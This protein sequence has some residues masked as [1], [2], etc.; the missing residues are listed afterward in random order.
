MNANLNVNGLIRTVFKTDGVLELGRYLD[1]VND[2]IV[3]SPRGRVNSTGYFEIRMMY[4]SGEYILGRFASHFVSASPSLGFRIASGTTVFSSVQVA[5]GVMKTYRFVRDGIHIDIYIDGVFQERVTQDSTADLV[6]DNV[7]SRDT[8]ALFSR[9]LVAH[10][11]VDGT[12][13]NESN[14]WNG[15]TLNGTTIAET[16]DG[17]ANYTLQ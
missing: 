10:I 16:T 2:N 3:F 1:G 17:W 5:V 14:A 7:G 15:M 11:D 12:M 8:T 6:F 4:L 9:I 13:H